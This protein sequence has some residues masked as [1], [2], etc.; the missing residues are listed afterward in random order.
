MISPLQSNTYSEVLHT[1]FFVRHSKLKTCTDMQPSPR[2]K[3][4]SCSPASPRL[5]R[6]WTGKRTV[7]SKNVHEKRELKLNLNS[8]W[9]VKEPY[10]LSIKVFWALDLYPRV[11][12]WLAGAQHAVSPCYS[13][14]CKLK[15][16][17]SITTNAISCSFQA[18]A[19]FN[20]A[21]FQTLLR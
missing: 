6:N 3:Q 20:H 15:S 21:E 13:T 11:E 1:I 18:M 19:H 2:A 8:S 5:L 7:F 4:G 17:S 14:Q 10:N 12:Q 9:D 16:T